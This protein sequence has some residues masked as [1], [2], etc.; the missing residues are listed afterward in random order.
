MK[1]RVDTIQQPPPP[2]P[3]QHRA[4]GLVGCT[5]YDEINSAAVNRGK[6]LESLVS[7]RIYAV[8]G[9]LCWSTRNIL[10]SGECFM[11]QQKFPDATT[12]SNSKIYRVLSWITLIKAS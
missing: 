7:G 3:Y 8:D 1:S 12:E 5:G 10:N 2:D 9:K 11:D 6:L 4:M